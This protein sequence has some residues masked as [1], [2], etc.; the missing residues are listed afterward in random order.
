MMMRTEDDLRAAFRALERHAPD[1]ADVRRA[2]HAQSRGVAR[3]RRP[4]GRRPL[5]I[6][7]VL[8]AAAAAVTAVAVILAT[9]GSPAGRGGR[10]A[11]P[12]LRVRLLAAIDTVRGD[13]L[14]AGGR[15]PADGGMWVWPGYPR[16][17]E[18][19]RVRVLGFGMDGV[20]GKDE[21]YI[22]AMPASRSAAADAGN[23]IDWGLMTVTGT[24]IYVD[25]VKHTWGEWNQNMTFGLPVNA[26]GIRG[27][28]AHG[29]LRVIGRTKLR[30]RPAIELGI[31]LATSGGGLRVTTAD[32]WVDAATYLPMRQLLLY[33]DGKQDLTDYTFLRPTAANLAQL[34]PVIPAGYTRTT[35]HP[36]QG[37]K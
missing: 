11:G 16:P 20:P 34:R 8:G 6:T 33:S 25:H 15:S 7:L 24:L 5:G 35:M 18:Q 4:R 12:A 3:Q 2:V 27:E 21:E 31:T 32:L 28:I 9:A 1:A 23:P 17:G 13:I 37:K 29:Q 14:F 22:F 26:A 30:G 19:V 10:A 36:D